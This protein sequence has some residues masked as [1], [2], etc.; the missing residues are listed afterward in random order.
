MVVVR[1]D[2]D[3]EDDEDDEDLR[4]VDA[5]VAKSE[6]GRADERA[7]S[8]YRSK[9]DR[10]MGRFPQ[11]FL[12]L[13]EPDMTAGEVLR[14]GFAVRYVLTDDDEEQVRKDAQSE[15]DAPNPTHISDEE[16]FI[17]ANP[18]LVM[19]KRLLWLLMLLLVN[20]GTANILSSFEHVIDEETSLAFFIPLLIGTGGNAGAQMAMLVTAAL[21][22]KE[23]TLA[24]W[25]PVLRLLGKEVGMGALLGLLLAVAAWPVAYWKGGGEVAWTV[26]TTMICLVWLADI[27]GLVL[28]LLA[29]L[30]NVNPAITTSPVITTVLDALGIT[31]YFV[32][33]SIIV[34]D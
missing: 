30:V 34:L 33:A 24:A 10:V 12:M 23:L 25:T 8:T 17:E 6:R 13:C 7:S 26:G 4:M 22:T 20:V 29:T 27:L 32:I 15:I 9:R 28:P 21:S 18:F 19:G 3:D 2:V 5:D 14:A 11:T 16:S 1:D 31:I